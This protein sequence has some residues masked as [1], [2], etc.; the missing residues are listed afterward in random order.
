MGLISGLQGTQ[1][2]LSD[3]AFLLPAEIPYPPGDQPAAVLTDELVL[4][5][6]GRGGSHFIAVPDSNQGNQTL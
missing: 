1:L 2:R 3:F 4:E 6:S 5:N